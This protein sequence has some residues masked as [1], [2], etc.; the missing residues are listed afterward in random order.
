MRK[1]GQKVFILL[2]DGRKIEIE[3]YEVRGRQARLRIDSP[4]GIKV[5]REELMDA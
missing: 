3:V 2:E 4:A 5:L 1:A